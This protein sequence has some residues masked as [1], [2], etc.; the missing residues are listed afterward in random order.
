MPPFTPDLPPA[1]PPVNPLASVHTTN[2]PEILRQ[3]RISLLVTT[4][5]TGKLVVVRADGD[6]IDTH[7]VGLARPTGIAAD[8]SRLVV[9]TAAGLREYRNVPAVA[10]R[11]EPPGR[12]DAVYVFRHQH[13]TGDIDVHELA[14][15]SGEVWFVNTR[16]SCLCSLDHGH[17]FVPRWRPRFISGL[18]PEDRCHLNGLAMRDGNPS[19]LTAV[20]ATDKPEGWRWKKRDGGVLIDYASGDVIMQGMS[21]PHSPRWHRDR[22]WML[23]SG[24][25][26]LV[27][28]DP[29]SGRTEI[30]ARV[31][32]FARGLDFAG[33]LAFV[34]LSQLRETN[35][36]ADI[37]VTDDNVDRMSGVWVVNIE[38]GQTI[39]FLKFGGA[40]PELFAVHALAGTVFPGILDEDSDVMKTT[41]V[42][43]DAALRDVRFSAPE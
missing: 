42:L 15:G 19:M 4:Y 32:G 11:L 38:T 25:G 14:L 5:R 29:Q 6:A 18:A 41:W 36:F 28:V 10:S 30:V 33:P 9:G 3:L 31:P 12:H 1:M 35:T 22:L 7:F 23:E 43:P 34:G 40:V 21:L 13:A 17:S 24:T 16:F 39:A 26:S 37:P 8:A 27:A 2:L 20:G